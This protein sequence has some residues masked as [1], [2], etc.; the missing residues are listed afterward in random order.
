[1]KLPNPLDNKLMWCESKR[2]LSDT[3]I[4]QAI[5]AGLW[6][7]NPPL[8][9]ADGKRI[10]PATLD[11]CIDHVEGSEPICPGFDIPYNFRST[12]T[13]AP[14]AVSTVCMTE[15]INAASFDV[16]RFLAP[17]V[18]ARSSV[19]RLGGFAAKCGAY[20][21]GHDIEL[22]NFGVNPIVFK[23][24]ERVAQ[25]FIQVRPYSDYDACGEVIPELHELGEKV[26]SLDMGVEIKEN[27]H[28]KDLVKDGHLGITPSLE[29]S[30]GMIKVHAGD[31][32][33]RFKQMDEIDFSNRDKYGDDCQEQIDIRNGYQVKPFEHIIVPTRESLKLS[34]NVGIR[35]WD[36][37]CDFRIK[38]KHMGG[39]WKKR[40][41]SLSQNVELLNITDGWIDPGY[42]GGF[43]RQPKWVTGRWIHPGQCIGYGAVF[44]FPN[45]VGKQYG[46]SELGSQYQ[47][48][49]KTAFAKQP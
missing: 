44:W 41:I 30:L 9:P 15:S 33:Y 1:M 6:L 39:S 19:R 21:T 3:G 27:Q 17:S 32:A 23:K 20:F 35:F 24:G 5:D 2:I 28:L 22:G 26:R 37:L 13:L 11:V 38:Q 47:G 8:N 48:Q 43:S 34:P 14:R 42:Q 10:Q 29:C 36:S 12:L 16:G 31:V 45:G 46:S 49:Q 18:E 25:L 7:I 40:S 4:R